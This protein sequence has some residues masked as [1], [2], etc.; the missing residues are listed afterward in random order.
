MTSLADIALINP[1]LDE[2]LADDQV[3]SF[4]G[5]ADISEDGKTGVGSERLF[6]TVKKGFTPFKNGDLLVAKITPCFENGK[7]AQ[8]ATAHTQAFG[9]TEFHVVRVATSRA[10]PRYVLH[11]LRTP[12]VRVSG[13]QRMTG[14]AGQRRVP[15][16]FL[17]SL[18][19]PLPPLSEQRRIAGILDRV[20]ELRAKRR[21][22]LA[23]LDELADAAFSSA[24]DI[25]DDPRGLGELPRLA[26]FAVQITDGEHLTPRRT[27]VGKKLLSARNVQNGYLDFRSVDHVDDVE[28]ERVARRCRPTRG[29][30][31][32]SC[33]GSVGRISV[34]A[35]DEP[36]VLVRSVALVRPAA[37]LHPLYLERYLRSPSIQRE[38]LKRSKSSA[39]ANL[40]Q[41]AIRALPVLVPDIR[42]QLQ[43]V[44]RVERIERL[45]SIHRASLA[46]LDELFASLQHRAFSGQL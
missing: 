38:I 26:D 10:E 7:I 11:L 37:P 42:A 16:A 4:L 20:D 25:P 33:S 28:F 12:D 30:V 21:R 27:S 40:F 35:T 31:L 2:R 44:G 14:S 18:E 17:E 39:Q 1:K 6:S 19:I 45:G 15:K 5:M 23:F 9:S 43:F 29:D 22:A 32:I 36:F 24:F 8:A 13:E 46:H 34:V 3:V 41:D